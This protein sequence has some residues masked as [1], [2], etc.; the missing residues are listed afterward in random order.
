MQITQLTSSDLVALQP[1]FLRVFKQPISMALLDWKYGQVSSEK[2]TGGESWVS[3]DD[4]SPRL[5]RLHCGLLFRNLHWHGAIHRGAQLIDL[6]A[7]PKE[8]G[9][10]RDSSDFHQIMQHVLQRLQHPEGLIAFGFPSD[11]ALRLAIKLGVSTN[12]DQLYRLTWTGQSRKASWLRVGK[13]VQLTSLDSSVCQGL[14]EPMR[15]SLNAYCVGDRTYAHLHYRYEQ[16]PEKSYEF[17]LLMR[18]FSSKPL[19]LAV[20]SK[21]GASRE[22]LDIVACK[23]DYPRVIDGLRSWA[24][25]RG[26]DSLHLYATTSVVTELA[27]SNGTVEATAIRIMASPFESA[28]TLAKLKNNWWLMGGDTDY[29]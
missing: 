28:E 9:L 1:L 27:G 7:A 24:T 16:R 25:Q 8:T 22:I 2:G 23:H 15:A 14:W 5:P 29:H 19:G 21:D 18:P 12:I 20:L 26:V 13:I 4:A 11:R 3:A 6:M 10:A 17:L